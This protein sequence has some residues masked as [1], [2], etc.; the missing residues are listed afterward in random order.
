MNVTPP[1]GSKVLRP[2]SPGRSTEPDSQF[3]PNATVR[4]V[5]A[6]ALFACK[7]FEH[8]IANIFNRRG[9]NPSL[10]DLPGSRQRSARGSRRAG[11]AEWTTERTG[12]RTRAPE[13]RPTTPSPG[14]HRRR[15]T[16]AVLMAPNPE[17]G[18]RD[19]LSDSIRPM[20]ATRLPR[21]VRVTPTFVTPRTPTPRRDSG[22][23]GRRPPA[24]TNPTPADRLPFRKGG[25]PTITP[26]ARRAVVPAATRTTVERATTAT[27]GWVG[28]WSIVCDARSDRAGAPGS[29]TPTTP[30]HTARSRRSRR[31][32][33]GA[34]PLHDGRYHH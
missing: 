5:R 9:D 33:L 8:S 4:G 30:T 2:R 26:V 15:A 22:P 18:A 12:N 32:V 13:P 24:S 23:T 31:A 19:P 6:A 17:T 20:P 3:R 34:T 1:P 29:Q 25:G 10:I 27:S 11:P 16:T 28:A 14:S 21:T 7:Y